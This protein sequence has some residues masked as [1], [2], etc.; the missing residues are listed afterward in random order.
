MMESIRE[1]YKLGRG[2]LVRILLDQKRRAK[3][4]DEKT[5]KLRSL[6]LFYMVR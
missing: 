5:H 2:R 1:L 6:K 3:Y 4:L